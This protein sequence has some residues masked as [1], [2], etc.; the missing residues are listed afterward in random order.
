M[1][2]R[3]SRITLLLS[4]PLAV[5]Y[6]AICKLPE[7]YQAAGLT[8][9]EADVFVDAVIAMAEPVAIHFLWRPRLRDA[10]DEMVLEAAINGSADVLVTFNVKDYGE[11]PGEFRIRVMRPA[12]ALRKIQ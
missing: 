12:E 8:S 1:A 9:V 11:T 3:A 10:G 7:H 4:V 2:T 5:E 6:G